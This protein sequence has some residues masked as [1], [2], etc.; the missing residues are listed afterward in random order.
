[1]FKLIPRPVHGL[2][3]YGYGLLALATP[4]I[5]GF[6]GEPVPK[7]AA[8][9]VGI[10]VLVGGALTRTEF[11]LLK[12][13]PFRVHL[14]LLDAGGAL[15]VLALPWILRFADVPNARN[16]FLGL[17]VLTLVVTALSRP[18]EMPAGRVVAGG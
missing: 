11:G 14:G 8:I 16:A 15:A 13:I 5:F 2:L 7:A 6:S 10:L 1:M 4:W 12:L 18:E 9:A 17:G 3:D